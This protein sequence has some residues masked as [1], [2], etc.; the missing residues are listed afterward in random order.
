LSLIFLYFEFIANDSIAGAVNSF[1]RSL[2]ISRII[3]YPGKSVYPAKFIPVFLL[4]L[5]RSR[6]MSS[7][8]FQRTTEG[9]GVL[10]RSS[11][12]NSLPAFQQ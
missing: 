7:H 10:W 5:N 4:C 3:K 11:G 1:I 2:S 9:A 8:S 6:I 12:P